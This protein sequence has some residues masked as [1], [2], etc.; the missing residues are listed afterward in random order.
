MLI[1]SEVFQDLARAE[2]TGFGTPELTILVVPHPVASRSAD[3]LQAWGAD[4]LQQAIDG[5]IGPA[6][7]AR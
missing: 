4:L 6:Q 7:G 3:K 2:A 1:V 5:L